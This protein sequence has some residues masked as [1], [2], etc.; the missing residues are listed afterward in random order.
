[1]RAGLKLLLLLAL[2]AGYDPVEA[3]PTWTKPRPKPAPDRGFETADNT[4]QQDFPTSDGKSSGSATTYSGGQ[5]K[6][7]DE[8]GR[9]VGTTVQQGPVVVAPTINPSSIC[10]C[11]GPS[12][13]ITN[14]CPGGKPWPMR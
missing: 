4:T 9:P 1:M 13:P 8:R 12:C 7:Y 11:P 2:L 14:P 5:T 10:T 3:E 6:Y